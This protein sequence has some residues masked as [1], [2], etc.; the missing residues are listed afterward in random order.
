MAELFAA[1]GDDTGDLCWSILD[2]GDVIAHDSSGLDIEELEE[3]VSAYPTGLHVSLA[4]LRGLAA[5]TLQVIDALFVAS[6]DAETLPSRH[7]TDHQILRRADLVVA[8]FDSSFWLI[9]GPE[10][11]LDGIVAAFRDVDEV[12]AA[13]T[14][15]RAWGPTP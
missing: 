5:E 7:D 4:E 1:L 10:A 8:A 13:S 2:L 6:A 14:P 11:V 12:D 9:S 15:L 3:R